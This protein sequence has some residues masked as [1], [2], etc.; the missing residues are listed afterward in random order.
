M[1]DTQPDIQ[2]FN[3]TELDIPLSTDLCYRIALAISEHE[4]CTFNFVE[5]VYVDEAEIVRINKEHLD[6]DYITDIITFRYDEQEDDKEIEGT[7]FCCAPRI[8]EQA[9]EF[10]EKPEREYLR[11]LIHG[12]LHLA[13]YDDKTDEQKKRMTEK[14][15]WYLSTI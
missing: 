9:E 2:L 6:R 1:A 4:G 15:N 11:I 14:E 10:G 13:G 7:I 5:V 12:L 3:E 8:V